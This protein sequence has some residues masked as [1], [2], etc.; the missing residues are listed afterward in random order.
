[1][2]NTFLR[3]N[4]TGKSIVFT[5][6]LFFFIY[7]IF[8]IRF[9]ENDDI[10]MSLIS[11]GQYSGSP[12]VHMVFSNVMYGYILNGLY[13]WFPSLEWYTLIQVG[14]NILSV[15]LISTSLLK[16]DY[17]NRI[18]TIFLVLL[19]SIFIAVS[20]TLQFTYTAGLLAISG[21]NLLYQ[22]KGKWQIILGILLVVLG[23]WFRFKAGVLVLLI[24]FPFVLFEYKRLKDF[25]KSPVLWSLGLSLFLTLGCK[26]IDSQSYTSDL[27]WAHFKTFNEIRGRIND[28]PNVYKIKKDLPEG[29][30]LGDFNLLIAAFSDGKRMNLNAVTKINNRLTDVPLTSKI[31][32]I[33]NLFKSYYSVWLVMLG[34]I[35]VTLLGLNRNTLSK[36]HVIPFLMFGILILGLSFLATDR[37]VKNRVFLIA[38]STIL[39]L[40]PL[41]IVKLK[42]TV[43]QEKVIGGVVLFLALFLNFRTFY[44]YDGHVFPEKFKNQNALI[45]EYLKGTNKKV[46]PYST[47]LMLEYGDPFKTSDNFPSQQL[48][49]TGW[50]AQVPF[51]KNNFDSFEYFLEGNGLYITKLAYQS[52]VD[53]VV[54]SLKENYNTIVKPKIVLE[55]DLDCIVEFVPVN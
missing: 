44:R 31:Q 6:L 39:L 42:T 19:Y 3:T 21:V 13:Q 43:K 46:S 17:S 36:K 18:Q 49:F 28:N 14:C 20:I 24:A 22:N 32:N 47:S 30:S 38:V 5:T 29:I 10:I 26:W 23:S 45:K 40:L 9:E 8:N 34:F 50:M 52:V 1:M 55:N 7:L 37:T 2:L 27:Q 51:N 54:E 48:Y 12:D 53:L 35:L 25:V 33:K 41:I 16:S 4:S 11:S 15:S